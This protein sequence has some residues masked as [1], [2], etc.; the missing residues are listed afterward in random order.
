MINNEGADRLV[1]D[2]WSERAWPLD[3]LARAR[4]V[5]IPDGL[6]LRWFQW[7]APLERAN[8]EVQWAERLQNGTVRFRQLT[9]NDGDAFSELWA[10]SAEEIGEWDVTVERGPNAFASFEL[11]ER[12]VLNG[13]FD[14]G[15]MVACVS[16]SLRHTI[17]GGQRISVRF[18]QS[19]RVHKDHRGH[20]YA[21]WVRSLPWA[22]GLNMPT[23]VQY[24]YIRANN[25]AMERWNEKFMPNVASVPKRDN[26][27]PGIPT[28]VLHFAAKAVRGDA[29]GVRPAR[30]ADYARCAELINRTHVGRDLFVPYTAE[31]LRDRLE[32]DVPDFAPWRRPY[33]LDD[34]WVLEQR[35]EIVA[36]AGLWDRGR[37]AREHWRHRETGAERTITSCSLFDIGYAEGGEE[38]MALLIEHLLGVT[39]DLGRDVLV[40]PL[41]EMPEVASLLSAHEPSSETRYLQWRADTPALTTPAHLDLVYW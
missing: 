34:F 33:R 12:P 39:H 21:H 7:N 31:W 6:I 5:G 27:V 13:L 23:R 10:N 17:V 28:T 38:A 9:F 11:Q 40:A 36:C 3:L 16:F 4:R 22:I 14:G 8:D 15:L 26:A 37:D 19:M 1:D 24:D 2:G 32:F 29:A 18:G 41:E 20:K 35:G 25:M 30:P